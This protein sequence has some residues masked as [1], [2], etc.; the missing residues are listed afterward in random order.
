MVINLFYPNP[1]LLPEHGFGYLIPRS[2]PYS[3]NPESALGVVFD[4]DSSV[5]QDTAPGTKITV[6]MGGHWWDGLSPES[7][8]DEAEGVEMAK[9]V[10]ARHLN[11]RDEPEATNVTLQRDCIPQYTVGHE[12][13]LKKAHGELMAGFKGRLS[14]AGAWMGGVGLN[15]CVRGARD[16]AVGLEKELGRNGREDGLTGLENWVGPRAWVQVRIPK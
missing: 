9:R 1:H 6:M 4:S 7:L 8:P 16:L 10:L 15:D 3:Q 11:I 13:R 12:A 5:G 2:I 14:V